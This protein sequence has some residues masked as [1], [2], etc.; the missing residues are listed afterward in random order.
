MEK[1]IRNVGIKL[2]IYETSL[3]SIKVQKEFEM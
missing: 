1:T 3:N 2:I